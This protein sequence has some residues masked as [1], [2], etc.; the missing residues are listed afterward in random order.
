MIKD[1]LI[2]LCILGLMVLV[3]QEREQRINADTRLDQMQA[4]TDDDIIRMEDNMI[5]FHE[6]HT[7]DID[8]RE[9]D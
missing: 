3:M 9:F 7:Y 6:M 1:I 5:D 2:I 4:S 8:P